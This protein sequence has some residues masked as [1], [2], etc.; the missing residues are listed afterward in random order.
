MSDAAIRATIS[1]SGVVQGVGFRPFVYRRA[2][3]W[4]LAG[5]VRNTGDAGVEI[6]LEGP[7]S[8]IE[9]FLDDLRESPPPLS[10]V[11]SI[12]VEQG[13][14]A[15]AAPLEDPGDFQILQSVDEEGGSGTIPPDTGICEN[16][17]ADMRD[18]DSRYYGYWATTCVD[19]G[20]R[21]TVIRDLPY[22]RPRTSM[23]AF[24]M[25]EDCRSEYEDPADRRYHAQTI[26]C[27]ECGPTLSLIEPTDRGRRT[28]ATGTEALRAARKRLANGGLLAVR[29]IGGTHLV[30]DAT[31][32][33]AVDRLRQQT[34]RPAKP[35]ALMSAS[36]E[37]IR[38]FATVSEDE[39]SLLEDVRRPIVVLERT[40]DGSLAVVAPGLHTVG[41]MLPYAGLHHRL[42]D[43]DDLEGPLVMTSG[44][45]PGEPMCLT[46]D[47]IFE[48]LG[49]VIDAALVHDREIVARCD[50]SVVR[51]VD[52]RR[53]FLRRSRGWV[54]QS[55]PRREPGPPLLAV[56]A[57]FDATVAL[58]R[59]EEVFP[60]Q[61]VGDV[62][63]P[64]TKEFLEETV[65]HLSDL[66][67]VEPA[68]VA[69]DAHPNF[70]T[71]RFAREY[72]NE[73]DSSSAGDSEMPLIEV[74]HHHAHAGALLGEHDR[75][76]AITIVA[77]GTGYGESGSIWGGEV[78]DAKRD[79]FERVGGLDTF[80]LPGGEAAVRAPGRI[81]ASL[82]SDTDRID[83]FLVDRTELD[84]AG[85]EGL[86]ES[87]AADVNAVET[88]SAGRFL[89]A[90]S[91][92]LG[93][94]NRREYEGQPAIELEAVAAGADP[95]P[96]AL[97]YDSTDGRRVL[98]VRHL[99]GE[100][101]SR[102]RTESREAVAATT[103]DALA[104]GL[105]TIAVEV[106]EDRGI[107]TIGFTGGV[108]LNEAIS[109]RVRETVEAA[110]FEYI[111]HEQ[112]P[113]GDAGLSYG[114]AIVASARLVAEP[115]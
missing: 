45:M 74:Q 19:C 25:C 60:S 3:E 33:A 114:Q 93:I 87:L 104:R 17:L 86:R 72:A 115:Q 10:R 52:G 88:T 70:L 61:H 66:L 84:K 78:L 107:D 92:M 49:Q 21:Y 79:D 51:S 34:N 47:E 12:A 30:C 50:D 11:E 5:T 54:P 95:E 85:V 108:A 20:P 9:G 27:P 111:D 56:G 31:D 44:N 8:A 48:S 105:A 4:D 71:S 77:D 57:E 24:P 38:S 97:Q 113:P 100:L 32:E 26:A 67:A 59:D 35:F 112:V 64:A 23:D 58:A 14:A 73:Q 99:A 18:P 83:E 7:D 69:C 101:R 94:C 16:C 46:T 28:E 62:D 2:T 55:L 76:R 75:E 39:V 98:D 90:I 6:V 42:F 41:V 82:L 96:V 13:P 36:V 22:D 15:R 37:Q 109:Q 89:D 68:A 43:G 65:D 40:D 53:R 91:A 106:A 81:L 103:Q 110:G 102:S 29:G 1:V 80:R 63:G